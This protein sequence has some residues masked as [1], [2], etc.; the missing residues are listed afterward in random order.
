VGLHSTIIVLARLFLFV[1]SKTVEFYLLRVVLAL[2]SAACET[3]LYST[4]GRVLNPRIALIFLIIMA[5]STGM[6]HASVSYLPSSF[7]M[8]MTMLG[9]AA[10]MDWQGG[11]R[12]AQG[13]MWFGIGAV[14][15]WPF[16]GALVIPFIIEELILA[17]VTESGIECTRRI[18][19]GFVR[20]LIVLV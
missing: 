7:A 12:T 9:T 18:V 4:I 8:Y 16:A 1:R 15:G 19:D 14:L 20:S 10:F 6:F 5:T 13:I 3:K 17:S 2:V 11:L